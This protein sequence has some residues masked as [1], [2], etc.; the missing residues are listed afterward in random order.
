VA[1]R[2]YCGDIACVCVCVCVCMYVYVYAYVYVCVCV[3]LCVMCIWG[4]QGQ[5][6]K[7]LLDWGIRHFDLVLFVYLCVYV[8]MCVYV[9]K[10]KGR[11]AQSL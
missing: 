8:C 2:N 7:E 4:V 10:P 9:G 11:S 6:E 3:C 1:A 5:Q